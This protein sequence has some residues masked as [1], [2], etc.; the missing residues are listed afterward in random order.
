VFNLAR[1][2]KKRRGG[3]RGYAH[4]DVESRPELEQ[5]SPMMPLPPLPDEP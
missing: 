5:Q 1:R 3:R 4:G 2:E